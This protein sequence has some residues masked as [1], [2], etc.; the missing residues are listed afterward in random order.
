[1]SKENQKIV[2]RMATD[3]TELDDDTK[4]NFAWYLLGRQEERTR[5]EQEREKE[6]EKETA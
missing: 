1:M 3:F 5:W 4:D 2:L 6:I